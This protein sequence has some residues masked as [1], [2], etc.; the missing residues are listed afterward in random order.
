MQESRNISL[1]HVAILGAGSMG[2]AILSGL[3]ADG[4]TVDA[5][6]TVTTRSPQSADRVSGTGITVLTTASDPEANSVAARGAR[7][8]VLAVKP[9]GIVDLAASIGSALDSGAVVVSV[10]AGVPTALIESVL[11]AATAVVR[12]MPNTPS[13]IG[14]GVTGLSAGSAVSSDQLDLVSRVFSTMGAVHVIDEAEQDALTSVSG[15]GPA[16]VFFF[17][18]QLAAAAR[19]RGLSPELADALARE[20]VHGAAALAASSDLELTELRRRVTSPGGTTE[21]G[22]AVLDDRGLAS[23]LDAA[24]EAAAARSAEITASMTKGR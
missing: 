22:V 23:I 16:Y 19:A 7:V 17:I 11:P 3:T 13:T 1:P 15:S 24:T 12:A 21:R 6:V 4:V 10:A 18:E 14:L 8:V 2:G 9:A 5:G 20:T